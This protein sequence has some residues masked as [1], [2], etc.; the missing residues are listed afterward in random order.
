MASAQV[1]RD[2]H[3]LT[4]NDQKRSTM[5]KTTALL[6]GKPVTRLVEETYNTRNQII[7]AIVLKWLDVNGPHILFYFAEF[8]LRTRTHINSKILIFWAE[9]K[10]SR[11][12]LTAIKFDPH[13]YPLSP[14]SWSE[15]DVTCRY[16]RV[17]VMINDSVPVFVSS[18]LLYQGRKIIVTEVGESPL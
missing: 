18:K 5:S 12:T 1:K 6:S 13:W 11:I 4:K 16:W 2:V 9:K 14:S 10:F 7:Q 8:S 3:G 17:L 15:T